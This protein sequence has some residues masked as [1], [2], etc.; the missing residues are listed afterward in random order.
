MESIEK[1]ELKNHLPNDLTNIVMEYV[2]IRITKF[3]IERNQTE[4]QQQHDECDVVCFLEFEELGCVQFKIVVFMSEEDMFEFR[5]E[6]PSDLCETDFV[7]SRVYENEIALF[8]GFYRNYK[9]NGILEGALSCRLIDHDDSGEE[10]WLLTLRFGTNKGTFEKRFWWNEYGERDALLNGL[11][12]K[13][14]EPFS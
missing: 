4:E 14:G 9:E 1:E 12:K 3:T 6:P 13:S 11:K 10:R 7:G 2:C 5:T 8:F